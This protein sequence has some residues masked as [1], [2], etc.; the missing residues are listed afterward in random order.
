MEKRI[1]E[2]KLYEFYLELIFIDPKLNKYHCINYYSK[3]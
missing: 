3:K 2:G 1:F